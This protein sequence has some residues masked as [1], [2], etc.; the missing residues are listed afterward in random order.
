V[1]TWIRTAQELVGFLASLDGC[2]AIGLDSES[3]SL[4]HHFEK[5]CLLQMAGER[6]QAVLIDTLALKDLSPLAPTL[7]D[8]QVTKVLHGADYDVTTLKRDFGFRFA[9]LFDTMIASRFLGLPA[10]GLQAVARSELGVELSKGF[11]K[12]DW[13]RRPLTP[14]QEDYALADVR[15]L[16][17]LQDRLAR[18]LREKGR[19]EWVLEECE[20]VAGLDPARRRTDPHAYQ[21]IKGARRL[22]RRGLAVLR[23]VHAWREAQAASTDR[24]AFK[25]VPNEALLAIAESPPRS[26]DELTRVRG[27]SLRLRAQAAEVFDVVARAL[28]TPESELPSLAPTPRPVVAEAVRRRMLAL[29]A[30]RAVEGARLELDASL[31]L[32][33]RLLERVAE[34]APRDEEGLAQVDGLRRWRVVHFGKALLAAV[35]SA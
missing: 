29:R 21:S 26:R 23:E 18:Q 4:Y 34:A 22:S 28:A 10:V 2:R 3:D 16:I 32:P 35:A 25:I 30:W 17:A 9:G 12:D 14:A 33:Q 7:A 24:P 5:V 27:A 13:S 1:T 6:G 20:V 31:V 8:P 15:H 11:Q 19:L